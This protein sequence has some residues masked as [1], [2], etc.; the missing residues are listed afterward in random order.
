MWNSNSGVRD[1]GTDWEGC[2]WSRLV[3]LRIIVKGKQD[4]G[5]FLGQSYSIWAFVPVCAQ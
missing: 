5:A 2:G 3:D 4:S 1:A